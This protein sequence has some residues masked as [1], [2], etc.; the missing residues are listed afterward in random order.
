M[1]RMRGQRGFTLIEILVALS[2]LAAVILLITRAFLTILSVTAQGGSVTVATGLAARQLEQ[3]RTSVEAQT[4][5]V[6]WRNAFCAIA[7][8][9]PNPSDPPIPFAAPF[10]AYSYRILVNE[11]AVTA[12]AGQE[13]LLL[14]A[15]NVEPSLPGASPYAPDCARDEDPSV[16]DRVRWVTVEVYFRARPVPGE[17]TTR[18]PPP[19]VSCQLDP[20]ALPDE[21]I[22]VVR[23]TTAILRGAYHR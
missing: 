11:A 6:G 20:A 19:H 10:G 14:P 12:R 9:P 13:A 16:D 23:M 21:A 4:T 15:W 18:R 1:G 22:C 2:L 8:T 17:G 3:L 5:R 7:N